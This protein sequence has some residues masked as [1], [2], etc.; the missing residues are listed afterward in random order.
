MDLN[1]EIGRLLCSIVDQNEY[2]YNV[3]HVKYSRFVPQ[4]KD[5]CFF[6]LIRQKLKF[7]QI[8]KEKYYH[9]KGV[10]DKNILHNNGSNEAYIV[11]I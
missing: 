9:I 1:V 4:Y 6:A 11:Y 3:I 7:E 8:F 10:N 5:F 2:N